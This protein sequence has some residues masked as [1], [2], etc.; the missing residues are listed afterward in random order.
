MILRLN[1]KTG[2]EAIDTLIPEGIPSGNLTQISGYESTGKTQLCLNLTVEAVKTKLK[3]L[4]IDTQSAVSVKRLAD[5]LDSNGLS[6][7]LLEFVDISKI[8]SIYELF[9]LL[10]LLLLEDKYSLVILD[11]LSS[12]LNYTRVEMELQDKKKLFFQLVDEMNR[13][14][15]AV[16]QRRL[17]LAMVIT[18]YPNQWYY[19]RWFP[20]SLNINLSNSR[21]EPFIYTAQIQLKGQFPSQYK[22]CQFIIN[23]SGLHAHQTLQIAEQNSSGQESQDSIQEAGAP[24]PNHFATQDNVASSQFATQGLIYN[25]GNSHLDNWNLEL[26]DNSVFSEESE[27]SGFQEDHPYTQLPVETEQRGFSYENDDWLMESMEAC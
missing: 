19:S 24:S 16:R 27:T 20:F 15:A 23:D 21:E 10:N 3:V 25:P 2:C 11:S 6:Y 13:M 18:N 14:M 5:L 7:V 9:D 4:Y 1:L 12:L 26:L 22:S 8:F 17:N